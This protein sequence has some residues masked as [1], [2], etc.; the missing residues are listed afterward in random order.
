MDFGGV[1]K[2]LA[3]SLPA[4]KNQNGLELKLIVLGKGGKV[5]EEL[6]SQGI[7][8]QI[9]SFNPRIPNFKLIKE[10]RNILIDFAPDVVHTQGGEANFHGIWAAKLAN[11]PLVVGEEIGIPNHHTFW[12][13]VF[14]WVYR[15]ANKVI[16]I[17]EAVKEAIVE[18]GEVEA[19]K[20]SVVYNP[21]SSPEFQTGLSTV[22]R[23]PSTK[24]QPF[25]FVCTCR[26]VPIKNLDRLLVAFEG[27][28]KEN[29][30]RQI[31][32][33]IIGEGPERNK[34]ESLSQKLEMGDV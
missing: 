30:G 20:V 32:L 29:R 34:L 17:S 9:L 19:S 33:K 13:Y 15:K 18:L 11:V 10:L 7:K 12:R 5:A 2:V 27:L 26:L 24:R 6:V 16:A 31:F 21:I 4:L 8:P 3:I 25:V 1:E 14:K 28:V 22:D 23:R